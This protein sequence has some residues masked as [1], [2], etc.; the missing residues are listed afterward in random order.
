MLL[1]AERAPDFDRLEAEIA[2][3]EDAAQVQDRSVQS[4]APL[5]YAGRH[6]DHIGF[7][8]RADDGRPLGVASILADVS[9]LESARAALQALA[10]NL[11]DQV[12]QRTRE[13]S[14]ARCRWR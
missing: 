11:E 8:V 1:Q 3:L 14:E 2:R 13:L 4:P 5:A 10:E 9:A 7:P 6:F 12:R